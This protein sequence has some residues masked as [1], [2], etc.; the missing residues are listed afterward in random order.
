MRV[1]GGVCRGRRLV[2]FKGRSIRPTTDKVREAIFDTLSAL[3]PQ[4]FSSSSQVLDLFAGS[5]A[6]GIEA[7]SRGAG[8]AVFVERDR[9]AIE[10]IERNLDT[11]GLKNRATIMPIEVKRALSSLSRKERRFDLIFL[12]PPYGRGLVEE[13]LGSIMENGILKDGGVVVAEHS[14]REIPEEV[15]LKLVKR[16]RY[17]DTMVSYYTLG[18]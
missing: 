17:G 1:V 14:K 2:H 7:L 4:A 15:S 13:A 16:A 12:D 8:R 5:G 18:G 6:L 9:R 11:C 10:I 3:F